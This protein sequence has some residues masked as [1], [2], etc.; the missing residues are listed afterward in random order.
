M[1]DRLT[2]IAF[3]QIIRREWLDRTLEF[4]CAGVPDKEI[5]QYLDEYLSTQQQRGG[6]G[7]KRNKASYG[8]SIVMLSCW[9][10]KEEE[11]EAFRND[12]ITEAKKTDSSNWLPLHMAIVSAFYP[13]WFHVCAVVGKL[14]SYQDII[15]SSQ[16]YDKMKSLYGDSETIARNT[17][18]AIRTMVSWGLMAD[19]T[20]RK[21]FYEA[22]SQFQ[23]HSQ[24]AIALLFESVLL[25][26][27]DGRALYENVYRNPGLFGFKFD[28][29]PA[30][31]VETL[32]QGRIHM[33]NYGLTN[34]YLCLASSDVF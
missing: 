16:I 29:M 27:P 18:Y 28:Y 17:R 24:K 1:T 14:F 3:K 12:L 13:F 15:S 23:V 4:V 32:S 22:S 20:K 25:T 33:T 2:K 8:M 30:R 10:R 5:R 34:E 6:E 26:N 7:A 19:S 31:M 21:G 11:L 9:F